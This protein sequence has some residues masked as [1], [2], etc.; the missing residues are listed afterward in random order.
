M[1]VRIYNMNKLLLLINSSIYELMDVCKPNSLMILNM[2]DGIMHSYCLRL[3][4]RCLILFRGVVIISIQLLRVMVHYIELLALAF[5][6]W[7]LR[8]SRNHHFG[9]C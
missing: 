7:L 4:V 8:S 1:Y 5:A 6:S 9:G 2:Y 3:R